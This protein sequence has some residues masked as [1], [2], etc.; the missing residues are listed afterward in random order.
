MCEIHAHCPVEVDRLPLMCGDSW[1][2]LQDWGLCTSDTFFTVFLMP[3]CQQPVSCIRKGPQQ[4]S[5]FPLSRLG[6]VPGLSPLLPAGHGAHWPCA[7]Q[8]GWH[9]R[10]SEITSLGH[11]P[12][13]LGTSLE[14]CWQCQGVQ[15]A[16]APG[17]GTS[18]GALSRKKITRAAERRTGKGLHLLSLRL[19]SVSWHGNPQR[20]WTFFRALATPKDLELIWPPLLSVLKQSRERRVSEMQI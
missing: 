12:V 8:C 16:A 6:V 18:A 10:P 13:L 11:D 3:S 9:R 5:S 2:W 19:H 7:L 17:I 4:S 20:I 1:I 15:Q 14:T